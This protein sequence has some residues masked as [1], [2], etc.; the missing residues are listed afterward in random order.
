MPERV[1]LPENS[2]LFDL[3]FRDLPFKGPPDVDTLLTI[4]CSLAFQFNAILPL[5][6]PDRIRGETYQPAIM[7]TNLQWPVPIAVG[8]RWLYDDGRRKRS[9]VDHE[10][11]QEK[12][13]ACFH[14][15]RGRYDDRSD[16]LLWNIPRAALTAS[17]H[18][19]KQGPTV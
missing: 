8:V 4:E 10:S 5:D 14:G 17:E 15:D 11:G 2:D 1:P 19:K 7:R 12:Q 9:T 6:D 13:K 18:P 3:R 16:C